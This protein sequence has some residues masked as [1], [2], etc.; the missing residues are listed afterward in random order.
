MRLTGKVAIV[1]GAGSGIGRASALLFCREEATVV[2][3]D[4]N[5]S[6]LDETVGLIRAQ[7][8]V[9]L[10]VHA[11][12]SSEAD[13]QHAVAVTIDI[14]ERLDVLLNNAAIQVFGKVA[15]TSMADWRK[16]MDIN[17]TGYFLLCKYA[18]PFMIRQS[19]G[20]IINVSSILGL[21]GDPDLPA[22]G[23]TK[24][25][26]LAMT[27]SIAQA[28][29]RDGIRANCICPGDVETPLV[30]EYFNQQ[31]DPQAAREKVIANYAMGRIA[32]P[33]D[34]AY[35]ALFLASEESAFITGTYIIVDGGLTARC[36]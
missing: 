33:E 5:L 36:Y 24:G 9:A 29:G 16:V 8:G 18:I 20:S 27:R 3:V 35:T 21:V 14:Y 7:G 15:E 26:I 4:W 22:Y 31:P 25:G 6:H 23:A 17:L 28:H 11:D 1:T 10:A 30:V 13:V 32:M 34:V 2:A 19:S 12:V